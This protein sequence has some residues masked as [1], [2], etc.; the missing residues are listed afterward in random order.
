MPFG[1]LNAYASF[2][3]G[4]NW[5]FAPFLGKSLRVFMDDFCIYSSQLLHVERVDEVFGRLDRDGGQLNPSKIARGKV[6]LLGHEVSANGI[7]PE[8]R[9]VEALLLQ[10][11]P[12]SIKALLSF[13][14]KVRYL[15]R[16]FGML[17]E[18]IH[19]LPKATQRDPFRWTEVEEKAFQNIKEKLSMLPILMP[20][21]WENPFYVSLSV[22]SHAVGAVLMQKGKGSL[23]MRPVYYISRTMGETE[24]AWHVVEK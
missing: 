22:G 15:S 23:Y 1:L 5:V 9:K 6:V 3:R 17:A 19:P 18:Y 4:V 20:P 13:V 11:P 21:N 8:P 10:D 16:S 7:S 24:L 14:H 2:Q 12:T